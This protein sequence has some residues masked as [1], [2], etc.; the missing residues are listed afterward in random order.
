MSPDKSATIDYKGLSAKP[1][2]VAFGPLAGMD[3]KQYLLEQD[4]L[5]HSRLEGKGIETDIQEHTLTL[6]IP[7]NIGF[8]PNSASINWNLHSILDAISPVLK[9]YK[10]TSILVLGHSDS[11]GNPEVN[12][13]TQEVN[14]VNRFI[15]RTHCRK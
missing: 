1:G 12:K 8:G 15:F 3:E 6:N 11:K 2:L 9:E 14:R 4:A 10:Y 13:K 5:L 7:G